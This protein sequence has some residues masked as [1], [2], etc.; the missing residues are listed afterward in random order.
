[1]P[2]MTASQHA[3]AVLVE[4]DK[5]QPLS[6]DQRNR[7]KYVLYGLFKAIQSGAEVIAPLYPGYGTH[8]TDS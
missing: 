6:L 2:V 7:I 1:M 4:I 5:V 8:N 3:R